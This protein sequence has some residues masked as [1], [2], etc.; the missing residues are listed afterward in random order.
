MAPEELQRFFTRELTELL[1]LPLRRVLVLVA[2]KTILR[3]RHF[4][5]AG[6]P[7]AR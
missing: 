2:R 4:G 7:A 5:P 1:R 3:C 6:I